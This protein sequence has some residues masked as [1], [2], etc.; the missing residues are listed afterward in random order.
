LLLLRFLNGCIVA[1]QQLLLA[2]LVLFTWCTLEFSARSLLPA[3]VVH[4]KAAGIALVAQRFAQ[5]ETAV[6][7][8]GIHRFSEFALHLKVDKAA[9][10]EIPC[11]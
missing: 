9:A 4:P 5:P 11:F 6:W 2:A 10:L 3:G 8:L 7:T 1:S